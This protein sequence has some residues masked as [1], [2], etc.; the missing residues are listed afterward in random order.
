MR[1]ALDVVSPVEAP[2]LT[3][4]APA[5]A[6][7]AAIAVQAVVVLVVLAGLVAVRG[8]RGAALALASVLPVA[9]LLTNRVFSAQFIVTL[10][11]CWAVAGALVIRS[12]PA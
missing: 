12:S 10:V 8:D 5:C 3:A 7:T 1:R 9:F 6:T 11:A 2:W 4:D